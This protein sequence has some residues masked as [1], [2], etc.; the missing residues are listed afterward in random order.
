MSCN[1]IQSFRDSRRRQCSDGDQAPAA[2]R[3]VADPRSHAAGDLPHAAGGGSRGGRSGIQVGLGVKDEGSRSSTATAKSITAALRTSITGSK[4]AN[5]SQAMMRDLLDW[6]LGGATPTRPAAWFV[7]LALG[8][9]TS[10]ASSEIA[11]GSGYVRV[12]AAFGAAGTPASSGTATNNAAMT[13]GPFSSNQSISGLFISNTVSSN[14]GTMLYAG[15][16]S[17]ARTVQSGDSLVVAS[18]ALVV[19]MS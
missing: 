16:L 1:R 2:R 6:S 12:T 17:A 8:S 13:F 18:G 5:V 7:G 15:L 4:L 10:A 9:P 11:T 3:L 19:S 14:A